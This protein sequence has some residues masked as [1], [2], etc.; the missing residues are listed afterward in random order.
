MVLRGAASDFTLK[1]RLSRTDWIELGAQSQA[2]C[3][4]P[5]GALNATD[6]DVV[7]A[8]VRGLILQSK[9]RR[10]AESSSQCV[11]QGGQCDSLNIARHI[12]RLNIVGLCT[13]A[14]SIGH[15]LPHGKRG[16]NRT[17]FSRQQ[18]G[19]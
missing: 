2:L 11:L 10:N 7:G 8:P 9:C 19:K 17:V 6:L 15:I 1:S 3:W 12:R 4:A 18:K 16:L 14:L 13:A 5:D